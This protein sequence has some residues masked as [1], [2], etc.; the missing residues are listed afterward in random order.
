ME[1]HWERT[2][3]EVRLYI[4]C[5]CFS[6][7]PASVCVHNCVGSIRPSYPGKLMSYE[8][9][10]WISE[11][12]RKTSKRHN[13]K[14]S[15]PPSCHSKV[16]SFLFFR[17]SSG[18]MTIEV[19]YGRWRHW[20]Y[21]RSLH[22]IGSNGWLVSVWASSSCVCLCVCVQGCYKSSL[23]QMFLHSSV[24]KNH[25][26]LEEWLIS[27][28]IFIS[29]TAWEQAGRCFALTSL[30]LTDITRMKCSGF[31]W[32][33]NVQDSVL[34][35]LVQTHWQMLGFLSILIHSRSSN[36]RNMERGKEKHGQIVLI[37]TIDN[38]KKKKD[39]EKQMEWTK[40]T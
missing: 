21:T 10:D 40:I 14:F 31:W 8:C 5:S 36:R 39:E 33:M 13:C 16:P 9:L 6:L 20:I 38:V 4:R 34:L 19:F 17:F 28:A 3:D 1:C 27:S 7:I 23:W 26:D 18:L 11:R 30:V 37:G 29:L 32:V 12:S 2:Q 22:R 15:C 35:T 25:Y 24:S